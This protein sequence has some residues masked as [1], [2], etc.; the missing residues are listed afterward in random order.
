[1]ETFSRRPARFVKAS[2]K[3]RKRVAG[4]VD[5]KLP[6]HSSSVDQKRFYRDPVKLA[7]ADRMAA[8]RRLDRTRAY[9]CAAVLRKCIV[10]YSS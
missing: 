5:D 4:F 9:L 1:M 2:P 6:H 7:T 8:H 10:T 3:C